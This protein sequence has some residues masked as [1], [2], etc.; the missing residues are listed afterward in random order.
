MQMNE[1][2]DFKKAIHKITEEFI[3]T[4]R[5]EYDIP[6]ILS[7]ESLPLLE[8]VT[9]KVEYFSGSK[10][11]AAE[12]GLTAFLTE[13]LLEY[14]EGEVFKNDM[15]IIVRLYDT[16]LDQNIEILPRSW[17]AKRLKNGQKDSIAFKFAV[18][19][20]NRGEEPR[21]SSEWL[22]DKPL[23]AN[24]AKNLEVPPCDEHFINN[25]IQEL[26]ESPEKT[27]NKLFN[28]PDSVLGKIKQNDKSYKYYLGRIY[29][30]HFFVY[31]LKFIYDHRKFGGVFESFSIKHILLS[32]EEYS[33][34]LE[35]IKDVP[36]GVSDNIFDELFDMEKS[37]QLFK[38]GNPEL[39]NETIINLLKLNGRKLYYHNIKELKN[40]LNFIKEDNKEAINYLSTYR[41]E[42]RQ[43]CC[44]AIE[45]IFS[46]IFNGKEIFDN[47]VCQKDIIIWLDNASGREPKKTW[48]DKL[49]ALKQKGISQD[50]ELISEWILAHYDLRYDE[51]NNWLDSVFS[52]FQKSAKWYINMK[53]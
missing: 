3:L 45:Y 15:D 14:F 6:L 39:R 44:K 50:L 31:K 34:L 21:L 42:Y 53:Y 13:L 41:A 32:P 49:M 4:V 48:N 2:I 24:F 23:A 9:D 46:Y 5:K 20:A 12:I 7:R 27:S 19:S 43:G 30:M 35:Y 11:E 16:S 28:N 38:K 8:K 33:V 25:L 26:L 29:K 37:T 17:I 18:L 40:I 47:F 22:E 52:R 51:K 36:F 10:R 1:L